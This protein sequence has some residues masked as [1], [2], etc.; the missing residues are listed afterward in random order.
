[1]RLFQVFLCFVL[2][3]GFIMTMGCGANTD[4]SQADDSTPSEPND[5]PVEPDESAVAEQCVE[6]F[7]AGLGDPVMSFEEVEDARYCEV[8]IAYLQDD[9]SIVADVYNSLPFGTCPQELWAALDTTT[10]SED[11]PDAIS[12][13]LNGPRYFLMQDMLTAPSQPS[14]PSVHDFGGIRMFKAATVVFNPDAQNGYTPLTVNR[15]NTWRFRAGRR[16][17]EL[18]DT[19]G[20]VYIMQAFSRIVDQTLTYYD[21]EELGT[22]L[23]LPGGWRYRVRVL[24][25][26]LDVQAIETA[27]VLQD[28]LQNTYQLRSDCQIE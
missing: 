24:E 12:I 8:L 9:G 11:F 20:N 14:D 23:S 18:I 6:G 13:R 5:A 26:N 28:E 17:H 25:D 4:S 3:L 27:T 1:M 7:D 21:L 22:R 15:D 19:E 10:L 2:N 16:V